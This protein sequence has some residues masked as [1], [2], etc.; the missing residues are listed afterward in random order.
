[1][2]SDS[3]LFVAGHAVVTGLDGGVPVFVLTEPGCQIVF[4]DT[5][6]IH[7]AG[8]SIQKRMM[9][10]VRD[11]LTA[12]GEAK[13]D[14]PVPTRPDTKCRAIVSSINAHNAYHAGQILLLRKLQGSWDPE[15]GVS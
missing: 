9:D 1:M 2:P 10:A 13:F 12:S 14:E 6:G 8:S 3:V 15:K 5:P 7:K 4:L 11:L